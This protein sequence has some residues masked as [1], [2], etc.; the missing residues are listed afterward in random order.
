MERGEGM[1]DRERR[2]ELA[3]FLR[4]R[5]GRLAPER[6]GLPRGARR[7]TPGLRRE[8][9]AQLADVGTT[10]YTWLEQERAIRVSAQVLDSIARALQLDGA[11]RRHLFL[12][13]DQPLPPLP[14]PFEE[15]VSP[16]LQRLLDA[17]GRNPAYVVGRRW[18]RIAWNGA[19]RAVFDDF[20][21]LPPRER[22]TVWRL[23]TDPTKRRFHVDWVGTAQHVLAQF[24]ADSA[25][26]VGDPWFTELI[27][28][29]HR[30]SPEFRA[31]WPRHDVWGNPDGRKELEHPCSG[32]LVLE[33]TTLQVPDAPD[34]KVIMYTPL[35]EADTAVK[36]AGLVTTLAAS[37][38]SS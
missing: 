3:D 16:A 22:N 13:A 24:R 30:A 31:W 27:D 10:W 5:R 12:L 35:P 34:L 29:L 38:A 32:R 1:D 14:P 6:V 4:T 7:R 23:F 18:D 15:R 26:H 2:R 21:T 20:P 11:E 28:D 19:A 9:V 36:L 37:S 8:E 17:Q 33:H 25:R